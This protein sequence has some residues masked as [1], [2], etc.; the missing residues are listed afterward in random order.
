VLR[1][2]NDTWGETT[3][4]RGNQPGSSGPIVASQTWTTKGYRA[5][6]VTSAV[7]AGGPVS[8]VLRHAVGCDAS[9]D[10][11]VTSREASTEP[12]A[13]RG[14][15]GLG[16]ARPR[17]LGRHRQRCRRL[18]RSPRRSGLRRRRRHGRDRSPAPIR[19]EGDRGGRH[20]VCDP[21]S[22]SFG[23]SNPTVCQHRATA[24]LLSS[25]DAA[26]PAR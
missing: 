14:R 15:D 12:A 8:F 25:G 4:D 16:S 24:S 10:V 21:T 22:S 19:G 23:G 17:L 2:A 11:S 6:D 1:A 9:S 13:A 26:L 20:I 7:S 18:D 5:F 3:I